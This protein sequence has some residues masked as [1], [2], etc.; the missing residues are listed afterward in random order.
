MKPEWLSLVTT[1]DFARSRLIVIFSGGTAKAGVRQAEAQRDAALAGYRKAVQSAFADVANVLARR[2]T[3]EA[4]LAAAEQGRAA[5]ADSLHL[6]DLRYHGG[7]DSY[8]ADLIARQ[9]LYT[10]ARKRIITLQTRAANR[11]ALYRAL[12]GDGSLSD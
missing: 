4:E 7:V 12:G 1:C 10:A 3:I 11:A 8:L 9:T 6:A 5:A 2:G